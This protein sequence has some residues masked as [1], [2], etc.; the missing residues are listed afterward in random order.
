M[1]TNK[2]LCCMTFLVL[3]LATDLKGQRGI[4][5]L[6]PDT[7]SFQNLSICNES[8][9]PVLK[10]IDSCWT[11]SSFSDIFSYATMTPQRDTMNGILWNITIEQLCDYSLFTVNLYPGFWCPFFTTG[12]IVFNN[13]RIIVGILH[14]S[15]AR[16]DNPDSRSIVEQYFCCDNDSVSFTRSSTEK[17][18]SE[19]EF[20]YRRDNVV[21]KCGI[22]IGP[23]EIHTSTSYPIIE[24]D[25][26]DSNG[27]ITII[28]DIEPIYLY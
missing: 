22:G 18:I 21:S 6:F 8:I 13:R 3:F 16:N 11:C 28:G 10:C 19:S 17:I 27:T 15:S 2:V 9:V 5:A 23:P 25:V 1:N 24:F 14:D 20:I 4:P 12:L 7:I 26:L